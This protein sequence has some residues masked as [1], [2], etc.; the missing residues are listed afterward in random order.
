MGLTRLEKNTLLQR[1]ARR[2]LAVAAKQPPPSFSER[3]TPE[4]LRSPAH[5]A[6]KEVV[7]RSE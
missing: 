1:V 4:A 7:N 2:Q 6:R 3:I 5:E